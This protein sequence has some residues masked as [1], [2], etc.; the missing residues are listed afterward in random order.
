MNDFNTYLVYLSY[1]YFFLLINVFINEFKGKKIYYFV[2]KLLKSNMDIFEYSDTSS[3][4]KS[5]NDC[6]EEITNTKKEV[7]YEDKYYEKYLSYPM[8]EESFTEVE[9]KLE[10]EKYNKL[11][12]S[13]E[14]GIIKIGEEIENNYKKIDRLKNIINDD[15]KL[16]EYINNYYLQNDEQNREEDEDVIDKDYA[17]SC[18]EDEIRELKTEIELFNKKKEIVKTDED[19]K[20]EAHDF[21]LSEILKTKKNSIIIEK[22]PLGN[23]IMFYN[24]ETGSFVYYSDNTIPYRFL[25]TV[26]RKYVIT[27]NCKNIYVDINVVIKEVEDK[28][29]KE[30]E[31]RKQKEKDERK[32]KEEEDQRKKEQND[33][34]ILDNIKKPKRDVFAKFKSYNKENSK[35][36]VTSGAPVKTNNVNNNTNE[37]NNRVILKD[38]ANRYTCEGRL[39]N[40][41]ILKK[42]DKKIVDKRLGLSFADFKKMQL[43][44][45]KK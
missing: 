23:V 29:N 13:Y 11:K 24:Y 28:L 18:M 40:Y 21:V 5:E 20:K 36:V 42:I 4:D 33:K 30:D 17:I 37:Q 10:E 12:I 44:N 22:T 16:Q 38:R 39:M 8:M 14:E 25:E 45:N 41:N 2:N 15:D 31:E 34:I 9:I 35:S 1:I 32:Q 27:Y 19:L 43:Q 26:S 6:L 7:K 3:E